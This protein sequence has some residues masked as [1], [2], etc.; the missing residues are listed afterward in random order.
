MKD[1]VRKILKEYVDE[2]DPVKINHPNTL[3]NYTLKQR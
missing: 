2:H 3:P 1:L